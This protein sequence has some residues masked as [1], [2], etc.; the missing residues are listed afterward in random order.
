MFVMRLMYVVKG[1][2]PILAML[3]RAGVDLNASKLENNNTEVS[4]PYHRGLGETREDVEARVSL[5]PA[6]QRPK[7]SV[8]P[9]FGG[10]A[11]LIHFTMAVY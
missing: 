9:I 3:Q 1:A 2:A 8:P 11:I 7:T 5:A 10:R 4:H 6:S